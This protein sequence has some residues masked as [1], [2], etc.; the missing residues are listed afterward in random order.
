M[1]NNFPKAI[2]ISEE[3]FNDVY[4]DLLHDNNRNIILYGGRD[5]AKSYTVAELILAKHIMQPRYARGVLVR[6]KANTIKDSQFQT[7]VD[8][9]R[10]WKLSSLFYITT[11]PLEIIF[12]PNNNK[13]IARGTDDPEKLKSLKDPTVTWYEE[14]NQMTYHDYVVISTSL[15]GPE[16]ATLQEYFSFNPEKEKQNWLNKEFFTDKQSYENNDGNF[17]F[18]K[19][20]KPNTTI[21][22]TTYKHNRFVSE[23]RKDKLEQ[24]K[25]Q[26]LNYYK[27]FC[28]GLWGGNLEG[29]IFKDFEIVDEFPSNADY[30]YGLDFGFENPTSLI[31]TA[32]I[33]NY[34][35]FDEELY[36]SKLTTPDLIQHLNDI[37]TKK[38]SFIYADHDPDKIEQ[39]SQAGFNIQNANKNVEAGVGWMKSYNLK[40][41]KRSENLINELQTYIYAKN[42][43]GEALDKPVKLNDHAI[44]AGRYGSYTHYMNNYQQVG[45]PLDFSRIHR[46]PVHNTF[47]F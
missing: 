17:E 8:V 44:D 11:H 5:S 20:S 14:A 25:T 43:D 28:L 9:I 21:L 39:I 37:I 3:M 36:L 24:L 22:H 34:L 31:K 41:T 18:V 19:S 47:N 46:F 42:K 30:S 2:K 10:D 29:L 1:N 12:K 15:R 40:I 4:L 6:K 38:S 26:D 45:V 32:T 16:E 13:I 35:Y 7:I 33:E 23:G 27:I